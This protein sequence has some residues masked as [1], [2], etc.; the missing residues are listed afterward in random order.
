MSNLTMT[1]DN[2]DSDFTPIP[3]PNKR[4]FTI[5]EV[6]ELC[7]VKAH[8]LRYWEQE[9]AQLKPAKRR[10]NRRYY[11]HKDVHL[12]QHIKHLLYE[13]GYTIS[14]AKAQLAQHKGHPQPAESPTISSLKLIDA[15]DIKQ[16]MTRAELDDVIQELTKIRDNLAD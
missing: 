3:I 8:V 15:E 4:Y 13:E 2:S 11:Q 1:N 10:G 9:F 6:S 16:Q 7:H 5:G 14:G 12:V